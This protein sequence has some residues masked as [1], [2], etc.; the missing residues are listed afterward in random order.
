[1]GALSQPI[2]ITRQGRPLGSTTPNLRTTLE[3]A[4]AQAI[5]LVDWD[6]EELHHV[7]QAYRRL[8]RIIRL[9]NSA[10]VRAEAQEAIASLQAW[11]AGDSAENRNHRGVLGNL[12]SAN[13][14]L[15]A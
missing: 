4:T 9:T 3:D 5:D 8:Q 15:P 6:A 7:G 14:R 1:M 10:V 2:A 11:A 13:G 12:R